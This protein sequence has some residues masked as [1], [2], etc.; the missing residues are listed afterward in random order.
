MGREGGRGGR[1]GGAK[2]RVRQKVGVGGQGMNVRFNRR[3][4]PLYT[5]RHI[6]GLPFINLNTLKG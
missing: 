1:D 2:K 3:A 6:S 4:A 5:P